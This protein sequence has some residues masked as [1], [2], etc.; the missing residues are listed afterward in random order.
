VDEWLSPQVVSRIA[1][2]LPRGEADA[3]TLAV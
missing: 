3:R 1:R 2:D